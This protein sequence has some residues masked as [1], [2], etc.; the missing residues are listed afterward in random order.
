M[1]RKTA[2]EIEEGVRIS[3]SVY[4]ATLNAS[5]PLASADNRP[6]QE[7]RRCRSEMRHAQ[8]AGSKPSGVSSFVAA[9][10]DWV[11]RSCPS[12]LHS[13]PWAPE[14]WESIRVC[15]FP[16]SARADPHAQSKC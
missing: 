10:A 1:K 9:L 3:L 6:D 4:T 15:S 13:Q 11:G 12:H 5:R 7:D 14:T 2:G 16:R 8:N